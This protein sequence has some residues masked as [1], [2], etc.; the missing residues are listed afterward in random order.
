MS[1]ISDY[2]NI[3]QISIYTDV[4]VFH[5]SDVSHYQQPIV[6]VTGCYNILVI[7]EAYFQ[8]TAM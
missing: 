5:L 1:S 3:K 4:E 2:V 6:K 7:S 8:L